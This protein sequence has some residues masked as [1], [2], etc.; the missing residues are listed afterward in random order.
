MS[1]GRC[2]LPVAAF[3]NGKDIDVFASNYAKNLDLD[4]TLARITGNYALAQGN[5]QLANE[6]YRQSI[7]LEATPDPL[8]DWD[9]L[10]RN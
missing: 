1:K 8:N 9:W 3:F 6:A 5:H 7:L 10:I 4:D 2:T